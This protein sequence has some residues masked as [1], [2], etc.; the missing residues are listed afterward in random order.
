MLFYIQIIIYY[1]YYAMS[2]NTYVGVIGAGS[3]GTAIANLLAENHPVLL[4]ERNE[5][6]VETLM[7]TRKIKNYDLHPRIEFTTDK[8]R[9]ARECYL[10]F[11]VVPSQY[12]KDMIIEFS[13][14]LRPDHLMIHAT[15]G[16]H[17]EFDIDK[18]N[19]TDIRLKDIKTMTE[20]I[21]EQTG[22]VRVGCLA[23]P[24]LA[25]EIQEKQP[26]AT[27]IASR[28]DE[29][30][31]E[32]QNALRSERFQV[33]GSRDLLGIEL[34][35]VLKN[36]VALASGA[37]SGLGY[38]ENARA[39]LITRGMAEM[40]YIGRSLGAESR[41]FLGLAGIGDLIATCSSPKSRN[42]TVGYRV[43]KGE[44]LENILADLGEVAEGVRTVKIAKLII[45]H[46]GAHAPLLQTI[47][48]ILFENM[49]IDTAIR[50][51][52]RMQVHADAEYLEV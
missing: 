8:E 9:L 47:Y 6:L 38:G 52:M 30:I 27:V 46:T 18:V 35:G 10:I 4:Y 36:Y 16:L 43:A 45:E 20:L 40:I 50:L 3:F 31:R 11:P 12:F 14:Y 48:K 13:P 19:A 26:A 49:R 15:K 5:A 21:L 28:F 41:S 44:K 7:R 17:C 22:I 32:G 23:G 2:D 51:L 24:N 25:A 33:Y 39:L 37:L 34:A 1:V 42:F 29:V